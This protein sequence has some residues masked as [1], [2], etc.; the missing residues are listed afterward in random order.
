MTIHIDPR[1]FPDALAMAQG[2]SLQVFAS[3]RYKLSFHTSP[4]QRLE[5]YGELP[6]RYREAYQKQR[7]RSAEAI[8]Q[9]FVLVDALSEP[10]WCLIHRMHLKGD[11]NATADNA[12]IVTD[13]DTHIAHVIMGDVHHQWTLPEAVIKKLMSAEGP[14]KGASSCFNEYMPSY[15]HDWLDAAFRLQDYRSGYRPTNTKPNR[16]IVPS[17]TDPDLCF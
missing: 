11:N 12:H 16:S 2:Y 6:K 14:R 5:Y 10:N 15:D 8:P 9:H 3:G 13:T 4:T 17:N 7:H 1:F